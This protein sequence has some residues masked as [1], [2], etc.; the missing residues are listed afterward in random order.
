MTRF[1]SWLRREPT[2][3][4][5]I[6]ATIVAFFVVDLFWNFFYPTKEVAKLLTSYLGAATQPVSYGFGSMSV[7]QR[8]M[9]LNVLNPLFEEAVYRLIPLAV[10]VRLSRRFGWLCVAVM[11]LESS[12]FFALRHGALLWLP[13]LTGSGIIYCLAFLK[14]GGSQGKLLKPYLAC[15]LIHVLWNSQVGAW[16]LAILHRVAESAL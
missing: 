9:Y 15:V 5:G 12:Y 14:L 7:L 4:C 13:L 11:V 3:L 8:I 2:S 16:S 1:V 10:A 6:S